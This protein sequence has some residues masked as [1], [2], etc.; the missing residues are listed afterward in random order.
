MERPHKLYHRNKPLTESDSENSTTSSVDFDESMRN[1]FKLAE[2]I[3]LA[4]R[5]SRL[6]KISAAEAPCVASGDHVLAPS[7][8]TSLDCPEDF[9]STALVDVEPYTVSE[10]VV[11]YLLGRTDVRPDEWD[12]ELQLWA[13]DAWNS[14]KNPPEELQAWMFVACCKFIPCNSVRM[15]KMT[16]AANNLKMARAFTEI[17]SHAESM[18]KWKALGEEMSSPDMMAGMIASLYLNLSREV[19]SACTM[20]KVSFMNS[21]TSI[22]MAIDKCE[23]VK[24]ELMQCSA[25]MQLEGNLD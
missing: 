24:T 5:K 11:S 25:M 2:K 12:L 18:E 10:D 9:S 7:A 17:D 4:A 22:K 20:M 15:M 14:L 13:S 1:A 6:C 19:E 23:Q 8:S 21:P 16:S 3:Q